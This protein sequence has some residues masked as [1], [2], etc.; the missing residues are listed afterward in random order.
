MV[1]ATENNTVRRANSSSSLASKPL[2]S[3]DLNF[4]STLVP[5]VSSGNFST[6][7]PANFFCNNDSNKRIKLCF[8]SFMAAHPKKKDAELESCTSA[9]ACFTNDQEQIFGVAD[10]VGEWQ[11]FGLDPS[12]FSKELMQ[13]FQNEFMSIRLSNAINDLETSGY[14]ENILNLAYK[15]TKNYGSSTALLG[16]CRNSYLYTLSIGDSGYAVLRPRENSAKLIEIYRSCEQQHSFNCPFQLSRLPEPKDFEELIRKGLGSF[17]SLVKRSTNSKQDLPEDGDSNVI[18]LQPFDIIIAGSD[19]LF[20]NLYEN[21]ILN[22]SE[23]YLSLGLCPEE[24]CNK[25][26][27][28][29]VL[30][31]IHKGWD[32]SHKSPFSKNASRYGKRYIGGKLDDTS[33]IVA[34]A[35]EEVR[36]TET[37]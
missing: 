25:L 15:K 33:V 13:N 6:L 27:R 11:T 3:P 28:E 32:T 31:A 5:R 8:G 24:F 29:L 4:T 26:A 1:I 16:M 17:V 7:R 21:D 10:G 20:D 2:L 22:I 36:D 12:L 34:L 23:K 9:D 35:I 19:G 14:L 37:T 18:P 30:E